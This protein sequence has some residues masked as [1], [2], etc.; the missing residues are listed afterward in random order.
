MK[1]SSDRHL[2]AR[3]ARGL[4]LFAASD[5]EQATRS[6]DGGGRG[7]VDPAL[8]LAATMRASWPTGPAA[9]SRRFGVDETPRRSALRQAACL[10]ADIG[11]RAHPDYRGKQSL[12]HHRPCRRSSASTIPAAPISRLTNLL[13]PRGQLDDAGAPPEIA[14]RRRRL[15]SGR[16]LLGALFRVAYLLSASM[17]GVVPR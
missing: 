12:N 9:P 2:R 7:T 1:P 8:A 11:W 3:R 10:L 6:A 13:P 16:A 17:P 14:A 15:M 4:S 5:E